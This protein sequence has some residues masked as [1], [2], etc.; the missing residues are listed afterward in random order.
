MKKKLTKLLATTL[1][2]VLT[3]VSLT[4]CASSA[5]EANAASKEDEKEIAAD[6]T[7]DNNASNSGEAVGSSSGGDEKVIKVGTGAVW[8]PFLFL[9]E[10]ENL[11]GYDID[12]V[13]AVADKLG[14]KVEF[15]IEEFGV[16]FSSL[17]SGKYDLITFELGKTDERAENYLR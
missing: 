10:D 12:V 11:V 5:S 13:N 6:S 9:D 14:Y 15:D 1:A 3:T 17:T 2:A 8:K 7:D 16:L 4:A